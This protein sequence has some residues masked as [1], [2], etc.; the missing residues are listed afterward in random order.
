LEHKWK[1]KPAELFKE[2]LTSV[3][4]DIDKDNKVLIFSDVHNQLCFAIIYGLSF[5]SPL[6]LMPAQVSSLS[7]Q[8]NVKNL[9]DH[10]SVWLD[11][12][13]PN[14]SAESR[15]RVS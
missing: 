15:E 7:L 9:L 2:R 5:N 10:S 3:L 8:L 1:G 11:V 14:S 13:C 12:A 4:G 6:T